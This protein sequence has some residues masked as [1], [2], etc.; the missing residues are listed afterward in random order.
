MMFSASDIRGGSHKK[1]LVTSGDRYKEPAKQVTASRKLEG[2]TRLF[3]LLNLK[4]C[5][6]TL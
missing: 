5:Y 3:P 4:E 1:I 6:R 2:F